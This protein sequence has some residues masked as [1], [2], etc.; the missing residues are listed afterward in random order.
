MTRSLKKIALI[1]SIGTLVS[2]IGGLARQLV[3]AGAFGVGAAYDAYNYAY[4]LP[5]FF[6]ILLG[7]I[8]GPFHN[9]IVTVL[10]RKSK[11]EGSYVLAAINTLV[12]AVLIVIT[13]SDI[14]E[15]IQAKK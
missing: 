15:T 2:K 13:A 3:I 8:N 12:S 4:V 14:A 10:S 9:A 5:G 11:Q 7:G 6:L 1:V